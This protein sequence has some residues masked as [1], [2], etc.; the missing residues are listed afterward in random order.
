MNSLFS[1]WKMAGGGNDFIMLDGVSQNLPE[2]EPERI[3]RLCS[4]GMS[5]GADGLIALVPSDRASVRMLHWNA[6]GG[7]NDFCG[8]GARCAARLAREA[9]LCDAALTLETGAGV[10]KAEVLERG[11]A[12][13]Q[14]PAPRDL[15][16]G[17]RLPLPHREVEADFVRIGVPH[18]V[19]EVVDLGSAGLLS[20]GAGLRR[21]PALGPEGANVNFV[22]RL[23]D[24]TVEIRTYERGVEGETLS[25]GSGAAAAAF[26]LRL[27][28]GGEEPVVLRTRSGI[29]LTIRMRRGEFLE[30]FWLEGD[31]RIIYK[32]AATDEAE[33]GFPG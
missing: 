5:I 18:I 33:R 29:I 6:D 8:N 21:H 30:D 14:M 7:A 22:R 17:L 20:E 23:A 12:R 15:A 1:F 3:R 11:T 4:R 16:R 2:L 25:C 28:T 13:V 27:R 9:G 10:L 24:G 19:T 31:A 32:G 26:W